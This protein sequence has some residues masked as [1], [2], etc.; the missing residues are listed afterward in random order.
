MILHIP[1]ASTD[2]F[3]KEFLC[4]L[5]LELERMTDADTDKLFSHPEAT[6]IVFPVSRLICDVERFEDDAVEPMAKKGMG[7]CYTSNSF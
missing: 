2:T 5:K 6:R 7:V 1:H 4:D 3:E